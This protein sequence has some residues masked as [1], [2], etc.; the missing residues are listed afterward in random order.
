M[1]WKRGDK[2]QKNARL[3]GP[4]ELPDAVKKYLAATPIIDA[5]IVPFLKAVLKASESG[6]RKNSI[7]IFDPADA[8]AR[9]IKVQN[10]DTFKQN[11]ELVIADGS[12]DDSTR[13][14][15]LTP[16][17]AISRIQFLSYN[18]ILKQIQ[19]LKEP[20]S[21]VFFYVN[22]GTGSGG[23]LGRGAAV[24]RVNAPIDGKK[25]KKYAIFG[26][27][28]VNMQPTHKENLIFDTDKPDQVA[29][30]VADSHKPRFC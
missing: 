10:F 5:S 26:A 20:G 11:P 12:M 6:D 27:N 21:S 15:D 14:V 24:I 9:E 17:N 28:V 13:K 7:I 16:R 3:A 1:F 23:P 18:D 8:E 2:G 30:W 19:S 25:V 22:A 4:V 29:K